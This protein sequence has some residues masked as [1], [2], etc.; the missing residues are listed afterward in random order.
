MD[1][2]VGFGE[3]WFLLVLV[4]GLVGCVVFGDE[5]FLWL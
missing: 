3:L 1:R 5:F 2:V 4:V